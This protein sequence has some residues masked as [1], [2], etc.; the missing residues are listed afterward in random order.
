MFPRR[1]VAAAILLSVTISLY[2][3]YSTDTGRK[4]T[5]RPLSHQPKPSLPT[6]LQPEVPPESTDAGWEFKVERDGDN[7]GLTDEQ[8]QAAFPKLFVEL[9]KS[10]Q[11]RKDNPISYKEFTS[12]DI[13]KGMVRG[14][15]FEGEVCAT[16][17]YEDALRC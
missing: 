15:I 16:Y 11:A 7:Y 13:E 4:L 6:C 8:C 5:N 9:E 14:L 3:V 2:L 10:V 17:L 1:Y 12:R